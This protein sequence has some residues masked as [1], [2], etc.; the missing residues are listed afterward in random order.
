[1]AILAGSHYKKTT[2][3]NTS[4]LFNQAYTFPHSAEQWSESNHQTQ[5]NKT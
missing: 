5:I 4:V 1:M 3:D 2:V